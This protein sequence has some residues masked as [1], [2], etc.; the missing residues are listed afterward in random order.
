MAEN[1]R[2][3]IKFGVDAKVDLVLANAQ[4][5]FGNR[6][7]ALIK[8]TGEEAAQFFPTDRLPGICCLDI[9]P[10]IGRTNDAINTEMGKLYARLI[11]KISG[12]KD[13]EKVD[14]FM[15]LECGKTLVDMVSKLKTAYQLAF[16][17]KEYNL[18]W[19]K[20]ILKMFGYDAN[21]LVA[22][23]EDFRA[24]INRL[25]TRCRSLNFPN[26]A[27]LKSGW[28][29]SRT[30]LLDSPDV[31]RAQLYIAN[32]KY[33]YEWDPI[34]DPNGT[35]LKIKSL[36]D[37]ST[38]WTFAN[39]RL[40]Y[41]QFLDALVYDQ[42]AIDISAWYDHLLE[43]DEDRLKF[44]DCEPTT[45]HVQF[46]YD[47]EALTVIENAEMLPSV[48]DITTAFDI[49]QLNNQALQGMGF[50]AKV[51][52]ATEEEILL[53]NHP[54]VL[55]CHKPKPSPSDIARYCSLK[56][57]RSYYTAGW[58]ASLTIYVN[59]PCDYSVED[60]KFFTLTNI[61][62]TG[63]VNSYKTD[64]KYSTSKKNIVSY[65]SMRNQFVHAPHLWIGEYYT[66]N[67]GYDTV[68]G[69]YMTYFPQIKFDNYIEIKDELLDNLYTSIW[70]T[71]LEDK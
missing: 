59:N 23:L 27:Y 45:D 54:H 9:I 52:T 67:T 20:S 41:E 2:K 38:A 68:G 65:L 46:A 14:Q 13:I 66:N 60:V 31:T 71:Q 28:E 39:I 3:S 15:Y 56:Y 64:M 55:N 5:P 11:R 19:P 63:T 70:F 42:D 37:S 26:I 34:S 8:L 29:Y 1:V 32:I 50:T 30:I 43:N 25:I 44:T 49:Y 51:N 16:M 4:L 35:K 33:G 10:L 58:P 6:T 61:N 24:W 12:A 62:G 21:D 57:Q 48:N 22:N 53:V 40:N 17:Y 7:G 36:G 47:I 18:Y 69:N